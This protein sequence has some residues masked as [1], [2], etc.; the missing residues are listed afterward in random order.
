[1]KAT[2]TFATKLRASWRQLIQSLLGLKRRVE[3][4]LEKRVRNLRQR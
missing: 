4:R 3:D 2:E 1:M